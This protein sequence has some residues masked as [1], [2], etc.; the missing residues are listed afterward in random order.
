MAHHR[1]VS[2]GRSNSQSL[3][4]EGDD[5]SKPD[6]P[7]PG[8]RKWS[9]LMRTLALCAAYFALVSRFRTSIIVEARTD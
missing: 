5:E 1:L 4:A 2:V 3:L 6:Q 8:S 7:L 9:S